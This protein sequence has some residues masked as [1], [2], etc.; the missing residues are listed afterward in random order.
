MGQGDLVFK[1]SSLI[2]LDDTMNHSYMTNYAGNDFQ[3]CKIL[4]CQLY[5]HAKIGHSDL[6]F[7]NLIG[8]LLKASLGTF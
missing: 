8:K 5:K 4:N 6:L 2:I 1:F 7:A 3:H